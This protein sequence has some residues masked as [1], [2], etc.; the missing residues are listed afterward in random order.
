LFFFDYTE[1]WLFYDDS[2]SDGTDYIE[3]AAYEKLGVREGEEF[4]EFCQDVFACICELRRFYMLDGER[5]KLV[6]EEFEIIHN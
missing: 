1:F 6:I 5:I 3:D 4:N 2:I